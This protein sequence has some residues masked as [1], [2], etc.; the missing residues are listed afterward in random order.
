MIEPTGLAKLIEDKFLP[1]AWTCTC[2]GTHPSC[3]ETKN[4]DVYAIA[5][6]DTVLRITQLIRGLQ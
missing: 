4:T 3:A 2:N 5:Q 1:F 6:A